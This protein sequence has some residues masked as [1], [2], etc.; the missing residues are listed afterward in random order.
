M[1]KKVGLGLHICGYADHILEDMVNTG[2]TNISVDAPTD[3]TKAAEVARG[4]AVLIGNV[5]TDLFFRGSRS[6]MAQAIRAC[7]DMAPEDSGYILAPGCEVPAIAPPEKIDW[8]MELANE[9]G[10]YD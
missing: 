10:K 6:E 7:I 4:K 8:F 9:L 5:A 3:L 1:E 2:A